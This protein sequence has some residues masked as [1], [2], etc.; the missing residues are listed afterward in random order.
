[1]AHEL[2]GGMLDAIGDG[3]RHLGNANPTTVILVAAGIALV[4]YFLLRTR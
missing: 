4:G 1:M 2:F 3:F